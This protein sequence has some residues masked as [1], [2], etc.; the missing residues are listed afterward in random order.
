MKKLY[1]L[2]LAIIVAAVLAVAAFGAVTTYVGSP[3]GP[4][5]V[6]SQY[7]MTSSHAVRSSNTFGLAPGQ[8]SCLPTGAR[9]WLTYISVGG[10]VEIIHQSP[11]GH[12][13]SFTVAVWSPW[14]AKATCR[15]Q[16]ASGTVSRQGWC[17]TT[18]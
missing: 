16:S 4:G 1:I 18:W 10:G 13:G 9:Y 8:P 12:C 3:S 2:A 14:Q 5:T 17:Y 6:N 7:R 15:I 11:P